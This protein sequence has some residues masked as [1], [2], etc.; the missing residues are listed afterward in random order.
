VARK[1]FIELKLHPIELGWKEP[2]SQRGR[3]VLAEGKFA[4]KI[5]AIAKT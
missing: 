5:I 2:R 4:D 1:K 3:P